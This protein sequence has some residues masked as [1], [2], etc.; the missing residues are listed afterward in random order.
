MQLHNQE[1]QRQVEE[2]HK[3]NQKLHRQL[4]DKVK[5]DSHPQPDYSK[6]RDRT[7]NKLK[8]GRQSASGKA[9]DAFIKELKAQLPDFPHKTEDKG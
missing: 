9:I 4:Q 1:L 7:L 6:I 2:L 5:A 8:M 3:E